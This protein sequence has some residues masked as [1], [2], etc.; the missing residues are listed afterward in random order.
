TPAA[1]DQ[2]RAGRKQQ[3]RYR[4]FEQ[5]GLKLEEVAVDLLQAALW[6][7]AAVPGRGGAKAQA[8]PRSPECLVAQLEGRPGPA[9]VDVSQRQQRQQDSH[10]AGQQGGEVT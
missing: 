4:Q 3:T 9:P 7:V 10:A 8:G 2:Q 5:I 6:G 1:A